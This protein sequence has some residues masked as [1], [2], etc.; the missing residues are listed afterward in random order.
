MREIP[1]SDKFNPG[2]VVVLKSGG[3]DM[4]VVEVSHD[5]VSCEWFKDTN[6]VLHRKFNFAAL[7]AARE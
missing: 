3:P 7:R 5:I 2:D 1:M 4:T 6:E